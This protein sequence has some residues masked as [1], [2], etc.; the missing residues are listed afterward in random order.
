MKS[1]GTGIPVTIEEAS[2]LPVWR[3]RIEVV[4]R[5]GRGHPDTICD[6]IG[7]RI[8]V[9]LSQAYLQRFGQ[10]LHHNIDKG[11][12]VAGQVECRPGGGRVLNPMR[13][14]IGDRATDRV[15]DTTLPVEKIA[16]ETARAW[17]KENLRH[18]DP[19]RHVRYQVE[20]KPS[21][22]ELEAIFG[23]R[24]GLLAAN[25]TS[26]VVG[27]GP[28]SP[29][30][31]LVRDLE[32]YLNGSEFKQ[33]HSDTGE[34]VKVMAFRR[35]GDLAV[36][37]AMPLLA[38]AVTSEHDYFERKARVL[39]AIRSY[40]KERRHGCRRVHVALN[41][42]DRRGKGGQGMYLSLLG[43]SAEQGD[44]GQI[45]RGNRV[46]GVIALNRPMSAEA[47]A[48]KNPVSH[49]GKIY[50]VLAHH[51]AGRIHDRVRGVDSVS[52]WLGSTIGRRI[53]R[54]SLAAAQVHLTRGVSLRRVQTPIREIMQAGF[55]ELPGFCDALA[56]GQ[57]PVV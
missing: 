36:T 26:A 14:I 2:S 41:A 55:D 24:R 5:K 32:Q 45:G 16:I 54:P 22:V 4:E 40:V 29:V 19:D 3:Q 47:A 6:A 53:D 30:E 49:V 48:G 21:S 44:S 38:G 13:L 33:E 42:L 25:D 1:Q 46:S 28:L 43:T 10:I 50:N 31:Q 8:S 37:V 23:P 15:G 34:D 27:Y 39:D 11:L 17:L 7:D 52:I 56:K 20:L 35:N 57:Y 51:L 18:V 12:L 9:E